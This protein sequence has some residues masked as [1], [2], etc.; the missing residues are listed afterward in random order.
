MGFGE[1]LT[2]TGYRLAQTG[3]ATSSSGH[4]APAWTGSATSFAC[5]CQDTPGRKVVANGRE[6]D[7]AYVILSE[8]E[9]A[10]SDL[11]WKPGASTASNVN[12]RRPIRVTKQPSFDGSTAY[13]A[14]FTS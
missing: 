8:T 12:A 11:V 4:S 14:E 13:E 7:V 2:Q 1:V 3:Q 10:L 5:F 6:H 9:L